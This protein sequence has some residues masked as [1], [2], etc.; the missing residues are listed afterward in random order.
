MSAYAEM[1]GFCDPEL[2][3]SRHV[4][5]YCEDL[6]KMCVFVSNVLEGFV[7][8]IPSYDKMEAIE[9]AAESY[10]SV[11]KAIE[12][13]GNE[14]TKEKLVHKSGDRIEPKLKIFNDKAE[15]NY[16]REHDREIRNIEKWKDWFNLD[17]K[18]RRT[19]YK[20]M[21]DS[22]LNA[23]KV[24]ALR[25]IKKVNVDVFR[26]VIENAS[27]LN[28]DQLSRISEAV[29]KWAGDM[30]SKYPTVEAPFMKVSGYHRDLERI[31][32]DYITDTLE[33]RWA[34][35]KAGDHL[36]TSYLPREDNKYIKFKMESTGDFTRFEVEMRGE[37]DLEK[38]AKDIW[39]DMKLG[40]DK[41]IEAVNEATEFL[42]RKYEGCEDDAQKCMDR[43]EKMIYKSV[44]EERKDDRGATALKVIRYFLK[45]GVVDSRKEGTQISTSITGGPDEMRHLIKSVKKRVKERMK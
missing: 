36:E 30:I 27:K 7:N 2:V 45:T 17:D 43:A 35:I 9:D 13:V 14:I 37:K 41:K 31:Y 29:H 1:L 12:S 44:L 5:S 34:P 19:I 39:D 22:K 23:K 15:I 4:E 32:E 20:K 8:Y 42:L 3:K 26:R 16:K 24:E 6:T 33:R 38:Y 28:A 18:S 25:K 40:W 11:L 21:W 10:E